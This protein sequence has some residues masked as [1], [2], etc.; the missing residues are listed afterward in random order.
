[1]STYWSAVFFTDALQFYFVCLMC[2]I[3]VAAF[4]VPAYMHSGAI[5]CLGLLLLVYVPVTLFLVYCLSFAFATQEMAS[6]ILVNVFLFVSPIVI[7]DN[8]AI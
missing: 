4:H 2:E 1:M 8:V 6:T 3:L 5:L 7:E